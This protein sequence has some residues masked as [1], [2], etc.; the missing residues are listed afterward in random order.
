VKQLSENNIHTEDENVAEETI[1]EAS[2]IN[3]TSVE[4]NNNNEQTEEN[5]NNVMKF[6]VAK[7][8][9]GISGLYDWVRCIL[10]AIAIVVVCLTFIFRL[11]NV[12]GSSM[13]DTLS[14]GDKVIVTNLFYTPKDGDI[15]VISHGAEYANPIIK[16]VIAT[17]GQTIKLDYENDKIIVD[18]IVLDEV[19]IDESTFGGN[20]GDNQIPD[21][22]PEGKV[23]VMGDNRRVS[24]DSRSTEIGLIDVENVIGKAQFVA[25]PFNNFG[26]LY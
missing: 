1:Q 9:G 4:E 3:E 22:V 15:V 10:F 25:Y 2:T 11:V 18:G 12:D 26:Y 20:I 17:E 19:Y 21:V 13:Y 16:R 5:S 7:I 24:M 6:L 8:D 23:F 14:S